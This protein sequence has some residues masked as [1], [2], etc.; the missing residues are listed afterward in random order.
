MAYCSLSALKLKIGE[1]GFREICSW[2][3]VKQQGHYIGHAIAIS[4]FQSLLAAKN[5]HAQNTLTEEEKTTRFSNS[6]ISNFQS[7]MSETRNQHHFIT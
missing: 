1:N 7:K 6:K 5:T 4:V 2:E 3:T